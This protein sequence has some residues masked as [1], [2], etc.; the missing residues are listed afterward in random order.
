MAKV[1]ECV[2]AAN[3]ANLRSSIYIFSSNLYIEIIDQY[4]FIDTNIY[5]YRFGFTM[6]VA[7][8]L[9]TMLCGAV[10]CGAVLC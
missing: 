7:R 6:C 9:G 2:D 5:D 8:Y 4:T 3:H 10:R 1:L